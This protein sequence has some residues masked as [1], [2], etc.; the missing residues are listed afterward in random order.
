MAGFIHISGDE[1]LPVN[2]ITFN[3]I[4]EFSRNY[5]SG[6]DRELVREV[7]SPIDE[8]GMDMVSLDGEGKDE[9]N[10]FYRGVKAA[11]DDCRMKGRCG[12]LD[13]QYY[14]TVMESWKELILMLERDDRS[15]KG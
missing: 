9:F 12:E 4:V 2:S 7:Y 3:A 10:A 14:S 13:S 6:K 8:G 1:G 11:Y 5:F 15:V